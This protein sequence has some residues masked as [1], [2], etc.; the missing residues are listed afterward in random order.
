MSYEDK[1]FIDLNF[2]CIFQADADDKERLIEKINLALSEIIFNEN[3]VQMNS[4][5]NA[6]SELMIING[7]A[8]EDVDY[9]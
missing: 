3:I 8:Q 6:I 7:F 2:E 9:N 1:Y 4:S 5:V